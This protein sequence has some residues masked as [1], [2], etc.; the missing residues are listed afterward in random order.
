[1]VNKYKKNP[2]FNH[3]RNLHQSYTKIPSHSSQNDTFKK[4]KKGW[5]VGRLRVDLPLW[6]VWEGPLLARD[7]LRKKRGGDN[8]GSLGQNNAQTHLRQQAEGKKINDRV[9]W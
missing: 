2:V 8:V 9:C 5:G 1:M 3:Q 7:S 4:K 6:A